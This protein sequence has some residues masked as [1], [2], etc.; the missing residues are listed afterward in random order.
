MVTNMPNSNR[1][2]NFNGGRSRPSYDFADMHLRG[3]LGRREYSE[4]TNKY[5]HCYSKRSDMKFTQPPSRSKFVQS[6]VRTNFYED[7]FRNM[8]ASMDNRVS[9]MDD[10]TLEALEEL[11]HMSELAD[12]TLEGRVIGKGSG[13]KRRPSSLYGRFGRGV[14]NL[15]HWK[16][17]EDKRHELFMLEQRELQ[18]KEEYSR[19]RR[20]LQNK[21]HQLLRYNHREKPS[22]SILEKY[23]SGEKSVEFTKFR[24][25]RKDKAQVPFCWHFIRG[26]CKRG[27]TCDFQHISKASRPNSWKVFLGGLPRYI[28]AAQLIEELAKQGYHVINEP[29]IFRGFSPQVCL[30]SIGEAQRLLRKG[31]ILITGS[32]VEVRPYQAFTQKEFDRQ[33]DINKR[34]VFLGGLP[35]KLTVSMLKSEMSKVGL[36]VVNR[37]IMK[38][39]YAPKVTL[40]TEEQAWA[41]V[42]KC[43]IE[44][45]GVAVDVR[46]FV[47]LKNQPENNE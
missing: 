20:L 38:T 46:P 14:G 45:Y 19:L 12:E 43:T 41:L 7:E 34:S 9:T 22:E 18:L 16:Q 32:N 23:C 26:Y 25:K 13:Y 5:K 35:A 21:K 36:K 37:P 47:V 8:V 6:P 31:K 3:C 42:A 4:I 1:H 33:L 10:K 30:R 29:K 28:T 27:N 44:I 15:L 11:L 2:N 40:A 17:Y 24:L 39:G